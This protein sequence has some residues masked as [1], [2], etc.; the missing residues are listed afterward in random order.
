MKIQ[1]IKAPAPGMLAILARRMSG[2][3][4]PLP[5]NPGAVG[6]VEGSLADMMVAADLGEKAAQ[7]KVV[8]IRGTCPQH[9]TMIAFLGDIASVEAAIKAV[10][11]KTSEG[12]VNC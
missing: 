3:D 2:E 8:E 7:I 9:L 4:E 1:F 5:L 6:L 10:R 11:E 12:V